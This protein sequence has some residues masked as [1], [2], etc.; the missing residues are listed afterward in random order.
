MPRLKVYQA[1]IDG[2]HDWVVAAPNQRAALDAL[3]VHQDLFA[4]GLAKVADDPGA[5]AA[6]DHPLI[7]LR[8]QKGSKAPFRPVEAA[9]ASAWGKAAAAT[10]KPGERQ[11][12]PSR[13]SLD[14]AEAALA[15]FEDE[16]ERQRDEVAKAQADLDA[17]KAALDQSLTRRRRR[18]SDA[19]EEARQAFRA[20]GGR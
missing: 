20:A 9:G 7:P 13:A 17:R 1:E 3:D 5:Q 12:P 18:L 4:Q 15:L 14:R 2:L 8:R 10:P 11:K 16:A 6:Y 19:V